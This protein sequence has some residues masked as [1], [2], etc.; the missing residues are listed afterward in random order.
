[1]LYCLVLGVGAAHADERLLVGFAAGPSGAVP[2][3]Y[4][5]ISP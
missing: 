1:M 3:A 5:S 4:G 2:G